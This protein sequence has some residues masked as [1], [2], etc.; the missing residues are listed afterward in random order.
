MIDLRDC[1]TFESRTKKLKEVYKEKC[2]DDICTH[3]S[4][5]G[6]LIDL[7]RIWKVHYG[8][9][10]SW[11][12]DNPEWSERYDD[13][14][15]DRVEWCRE[16][17]LLEMRRMAFSDIKDIFN[18]DG[19]IKGPK[20]WPKEV[21]SIIK[22]IDFDDEGEVKKVTLWNK[23]KSLEMLGKNMSLFIERVEHSGKVTLSDVI[24]EAARNT[25]EHSQE[26]S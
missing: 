22:S 6:S 19:S 16:N 9:I 1:P 8:R 7:C 15:N 14:L 26:E 17:V 5:G 12:R 23:E 24:E 18:E 10:I 20:Y 13:A 25:D 21:S 11:I 4:N 3:V 2:V